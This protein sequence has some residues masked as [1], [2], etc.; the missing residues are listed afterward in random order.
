MDQ[1]YFL[2]ATTGEWR[3]LASGKTLSLH[4]AAP[5]DLKGHP[6]EKEL[7]LMYEYD[8]LSLEDGKIMPQQQITRGE[9]IEMLMISLN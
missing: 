4:R 7:M 8:A 2:D 6:A 3:S 5:E 9:M 1:P